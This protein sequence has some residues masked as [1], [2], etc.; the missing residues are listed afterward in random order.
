MLSG[1]HVIFLQSLSVLT[2][3]MPRNEDDLTQIGSAPS[4]AKSKDAKKSDTRRT[5][6]VVWASASRFRVAINSEKFLQR[7]SDLSKSPKESWRMS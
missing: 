6:Y 1:N 2:F 3:A 7:P 4:T 5:L